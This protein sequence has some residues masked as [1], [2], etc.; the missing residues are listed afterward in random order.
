MSLSKKEEDIK[1]LIIAGCHLGGKKI[2]KQ[3]R[4]YVYT[5]RKD[6]IAIFDVNKIYEKIQVAARIIASVDPDSVISV[7]SREAGQRAVYKFSH[8][9][10]TQAITGR[11]SPGMLTNQTTK[12]YV[13]PRLLIVSD[14]RTDYNAILESSYVNLPVIAICNSDNMLKYVDC[15]IPC[16]NRNNYSIAMIW[17]LLTKAVLEIKKEEE[18]FEKNPSA[19]V[20]VELENKK[21][22]KK[23][24][25]E[26]EGKEGEEEEEAGGDEGEGDNKDEDGGEEEGEDDEDDG[27]KQ[28]L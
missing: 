1:N 10:R 28:F 7:S 3:M 25:Q 2:T 26:E 18:G 23:E 14:P 20:N 9:T 22:G 24:E 16:N 8:F 27:D 19:Y 21:K 15:A 12:K 13:E 6:G 4:K 17:Y 5:I 11:W